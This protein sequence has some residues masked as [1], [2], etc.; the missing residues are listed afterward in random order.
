MRD[1]P[2]TV[3]L[4]ISGMS[5]YSGDLRMGRVARICLYDFCDEFDGYYRIRNFINLMKL[6]LDVNQERCALAGVFD[7][8][9][10]GL[11]GLSDVGDFR[12]C[13]EKT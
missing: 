4:K 8:I 6:I 1:T 13:R 9:C 7:K 2:L 3:I 5:G 10:K 11:S 12:R